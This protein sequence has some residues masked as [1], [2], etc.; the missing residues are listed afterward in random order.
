MSR[1]TSLAIAALV[2]TMIIWGTSAVYMRKTALELTPENAIAFRYLL[3]S[4]ILIPGL[5]ITGGWRVARSDWPRFLVTGLVGMLG[6]NWFVNEGFARIAAGLG[7]IIT[8]V[9]PLFIAVLAWALL[10]EKLTASIFLGIAVSLAGAMVLF[11]PDLMKDTANPVSGWGIVCLVLACLGWAIYTIVG[12]PLLERYSSFTVTAWTMLMTTPVLLA[13]STKPMLTVAS[14]L[15]GVQWAEIIF[16]ALGSGL[17]GTML[18][19]YGAKHLPGA[20]TGSFLYLIPVIAV[21]A[22]WLIL[23]EAITMHLIAGGLLMLAGVAIAQF[24]PNLASRKAA[25]AH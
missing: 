18:W 17:I 16:L 5:L 21:V 24:G 23:N 10:R 7:T 8:M 25:D 14:E 19:N 3:L 13:L 6:Y 2:V 4:G 9:E 15:T 22:G 1:Q 20:L 11:W 12:K